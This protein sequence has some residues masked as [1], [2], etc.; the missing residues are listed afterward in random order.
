MIAAATFASLTGKKV[1]GI[2]DHAAGQDLRIA[3]EC[4]GEQLQGFDGDRGTRFGGTFPEIYDEGEQAFIS[5][6]RNGAEV[7][8]Y[9]RQSGTFYTA[10]LSDD[11]VQLYDHGAAAWFAYDVQDPQSRRSYHRAA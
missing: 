5:F 6:E 8:G 10:Q 4:R 2:H 7:K 3:A 9:D 1:A 11:L